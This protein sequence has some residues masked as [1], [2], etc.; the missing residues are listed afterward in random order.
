MV[1]HTLSRSRSQAAPH[2]GSGA[3]PVPCA[4]F[5]P[6]LPTRSHNFVGH[7]SIFSKQ[8]G[9]SHAFIRRNDARVPLRVFSSILRSYAIDN[10]AAGSDGTGLGC[11]RQRHGQASF[12]RDWNAPRLATG[13][14]PHTPRRR[15]HRSPPVR[16]SKA[17][18]RRQQP[19]L[20]A[21]APGERRLASSRRL[22]HLA[23]PR[24][25]AARPT[26]SPH[27]TRPTAD[28]PKP[29]T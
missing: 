4:A 22:P 3:L 11:L 25:S 5:S 27:A 10:P 18:M 26:R 17:I 8:L 28:F 24:V 15:A 1:G 12:G 13:V 9:K 23:V 29:L 20:P 21:S 14:D 7:A 2:S 19:P 6:Y 16:V